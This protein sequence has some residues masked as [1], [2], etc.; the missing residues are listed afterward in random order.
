MAGSGWQEVDGRKWMAG[1]GW[2]EGAMAAL[3]TAASTPDSLHPLINNLL[4]WTCTQQVF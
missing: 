2:Q 4:C 3:D 1:S